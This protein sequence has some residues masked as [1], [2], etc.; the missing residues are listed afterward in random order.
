MVSNI[1]FK[2]SSSFIRFFWK[3]EVAVTVNNMLGSYM[4]SSKST[5]FDEFE[6]LGF[7]YQAMINDGAT[8]KLVRFSIDHR[9]VEKIYEMTN[10]S[11][12][13]KELKKLADICLANNW[14]EHTG[15]AGQY[16]NLCLSTTGLGVATSKRKQKEI[17]GSK[18]LLKKISEYIEDHKGLFLLIGA[19]VAIVGLII[20]FTRSSGNG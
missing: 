11:L 8:R 14:L 3:R 20:N 15:L 6:L 19:I 9:L 12:S 2:I 1:H 13:E 5:D 17:E 16:G 4:K 10:C 7:Y 18:S